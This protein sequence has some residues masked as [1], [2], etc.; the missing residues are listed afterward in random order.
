MTFRLPN[1]GYN[2]NYLV[3]EMG[4]RPIGFSERGEMNCVR[5]LGA[6]YPRFHLYL[7]EEPGLVFNLLNPGKNVIDART[8]TGLMFDAVQDAA[9]LGSRKVKYDLLPLHDFIGSDGVC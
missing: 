8:I 3:R 5:P 6:D 4:Y 2:L 7:K 9:A 1:K